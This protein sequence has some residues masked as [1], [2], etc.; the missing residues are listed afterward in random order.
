MDFRQVARAAGWEEACVRIAEYSMYTM[1]VPRYLEVV[2][3]FYAQPQAAEPPVQPEASG[4]E[5][6][7]SA[8]EA[9]SDSQAGEC[10]K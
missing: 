2:R 9:G 1:G 6:D 3:S 7:G 8:S 4:E 10:G 5:G